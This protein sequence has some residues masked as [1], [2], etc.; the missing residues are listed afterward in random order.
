MEPFAY[1][2]D[3][4]D[5]N[6]RGFKIGLEIAVRCSPAITEVPIMFRNR[7]SGE[8]KLGAGE[9]WNYLLHLKGLYLFRMKSRL[10]P[11]RGCANHIKSTAK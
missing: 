7:T 3:D 1:S 9:V 8:S 4:A 10:R 5:L 6:P 11:G 2:L